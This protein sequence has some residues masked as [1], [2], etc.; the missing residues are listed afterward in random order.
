MFVQCLRLIWFVS[1]T[2]ID[3]LKSG[4]ALWASCQLEIC[5]TVSRTVPAWPSRTGVMGTLDHWHV[6]MKTAGRLA[7]GEG[8]ECDGPR[9]WDGSPG[10]PLSAWAASRP[11]T[12]ARQ[13]QI[14]Q[15]AVDNPEPGHKAGVDSLF[16]PLSVSALST[17][18][19]RHSGSCP[20]HSAPITTLATT[21][22][23]P[24]R[25]PLHPRTVSPP[26][27]LHHAR[28]FASPSLPRRRRPR[29]HS[30]WQ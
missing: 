5:A 24:Q 17:F 14:T 19:S 6:V 20:V 2:S 12:T 4:G 8:R 27:R 11:G 29:Q 23:Q 16:L 15:S 10:R 7:R 22:L 26:N 3:N 25:R 1:V 21:L 28:P 18:H 30:R 9:K 13:V